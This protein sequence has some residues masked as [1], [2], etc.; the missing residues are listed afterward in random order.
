MSDRRRRGDPDPVRAASRDQ[1]PGLGEQVDRGYRLQQELRR[2]A[3]QRRDC[4]VHRRMAG[5]Q[6]DRQARRQLAD[7]TEQFEPAH[8]RQFDIGDE[9]VPLLGLNAAQS[10]FRVKLMHDVE[11]P[12]AQHPAQVAAESR[13]VVDQQD[14]PP[15]TTRVTSLHESPSLANAALC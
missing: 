1:L 13:I 7:P 6:G 5:E 12:R 9:Q 11:A 3:A 14:A 8:A 2:R 4:V 10:S 15:L